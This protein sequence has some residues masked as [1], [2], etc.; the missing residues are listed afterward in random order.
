MKKHI[1]KWTLIILTLSIYVIVG[2]EQEHNTYTIS[3]HHNDLIHIDPLMFDANNPGKELAKYIEVLSITPLENT[4]EAFQGHIDKILEIDGMFII[5]DKKIHSVK[6]FDKTGKYLFEL[7]RKVRGPG[8]FLKVFDIG[9]HFR[10]HLIYIYDLS[11]RKLLFYNLQGS[12]IA[13][14]SVPFYGDRVV[15]VGRDYIFYVN[16]NYN[17]E[18]SQNYNL[19]VTNDKIQIKNKLF[20]YFHSDPPNITFSGF[21]VKNH[22]GAIHTGA[23]EDSIFQITDSCI[24]P[25]Y[26]INMGS[27]KAPRELMDNPSN[28][29][30]NLLD[31]TFLTNIV[32]DTEN[33]I[34]FQ[35]VYK[36]KNTNCAY[37]K[38]AR[39][40]FTSLDYKTPSLL[41][42]FEVFN[43]LNDNTIIAAVN[44][45]RIRYILDNYPS[46]VIYLNEYFPKLYHEIKD[47]K[48]DDNWIVFIVKIKS[49]RV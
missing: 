8:E 40:T 3:N 29:I 5:S 32:A 16:Y 24:Y 35:F 41:S 18:Y 26:V 31:H 46:H 37:I 47:V 22:L 10:K 45:S 13:E 34:L 11:S 49:E 9:Y 48:E 44:A 42:Y 17:H 25:S 6:V 30:G 7:G 33:A 36:R 1:T 4:E 38:D 39:L 43:S 28:L 27:N 15:D 19:L 23:L 12:F 14:K 2:C 20:P 21:L